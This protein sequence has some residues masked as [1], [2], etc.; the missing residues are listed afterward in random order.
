MYQPAGKEQRSR[1]DRYLSVT[2]PQES[3]YLVPM[4]SVSCGFVMPPSIS[5]F[6]SNLPTIGDRIRDQVGLPAV[7]DGIDIG[8]YP[9]QAFDEVGIWL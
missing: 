9:L 4:G 2:W 6:A 5:Y 8:N 3:A 1:K 7:A